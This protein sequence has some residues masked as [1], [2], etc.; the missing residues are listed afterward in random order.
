MDVDT[1]ARWMS[2]FDRSTF[3][4][5]VMTLGLGNPDIYEIK[6]LMKASSSTMK[7]V[8]AFKRTCLSLGMPS[9]KPVREEMKPSS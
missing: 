5:C 9:R 4:A 7:V 8:P 6:R 2:G 1:G 3:V